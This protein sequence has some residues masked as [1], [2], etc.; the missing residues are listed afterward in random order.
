MS[1]DGVW[2]SWLPHPAEDIVGV[3]DNDRA[4]M[5][6][7]DLRPGT[8][9]SNG[10]LAH[11]NRGTAPTPAE[12]TPIGAQ[13]RAREP[14]PP[15][16]DRVKRTAAPTDI[17]RSVVCGVDRSVSGRAAHQQAALFAEPGG[18]VEAVPG[19]RLTRQGEHA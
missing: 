18:T 8:P 15:P 19:P 9:E 12:P 7:A 1:R 2:S 16:A 17:F 5:P 14:P 6:R 3:M 11:G 4:V 13:G 10:A